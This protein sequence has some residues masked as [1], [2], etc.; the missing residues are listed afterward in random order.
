MICALGGHPKWCFATITQNGEPVT[1]GPF[2]ESKE[3]LAG[4]WI[5]KV[6]SAERAWEI[7]ARGSVPLG[8]PI[9]VRQVMEGPAADDVPARESADLS[10]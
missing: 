8:M 4:Y 10:V 6:E 3:F 5:V 2:A 1:D 7:A 9:E